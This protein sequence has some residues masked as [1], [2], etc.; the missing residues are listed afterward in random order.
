MF[1]IELL[2]KMCQW[3]ALFTPG[4]RGIALG[5]DREV[6]VAGSCSDISTQ[7]V[8]HFSLPFGECVVHKNWS[9]TAESEYTNGT[10]I[11]H[12]RQVGILWPVR[13]VAK[14][15][16]NEMSRTTD[17][18]HINAHGC[19]WAEKRCVVISCFSCHH[20]KC[21]IFRHIKYVNVALLYFCPDSDNS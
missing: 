19:K 21:H 12:C 15:P 18:V 11:W 9:V 1:F 16:V 8:S 3:C 6:D 10:H 7:E 4:H 20:I 5:W 14:C 2:S 13:S 17:N